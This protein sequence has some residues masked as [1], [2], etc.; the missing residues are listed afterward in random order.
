MR[1]NRREQGGVNM[2]L[3]AQVCIERERRECC[4]MIEFS[5]ANKSYK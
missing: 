4:G 5:E 3:I 1:K 2:I